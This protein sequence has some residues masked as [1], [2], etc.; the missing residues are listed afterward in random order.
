MQ[1]E[2]FR[3]ENIDGYRREGADVFA[4]LKFTRTLDGEVVGEEM[5]ELRLCGF[6][7]RDHADIMEA[8]VTELMERL[9]QESGNEDTGDSVPS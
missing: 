2:R 7:D 5:M 8:I 6:A 1:E 3:C 9:R 4:T